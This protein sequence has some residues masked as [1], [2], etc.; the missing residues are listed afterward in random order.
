MSAR[1]R[2]EG[3]LIM[4]YGRRNFRLLLWMR[5][6]RVRKFQNLPKVTQPMR[7]KVIGAQFC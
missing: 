4:T 3:H 6:L 7:R 2:A 1:H 5:K